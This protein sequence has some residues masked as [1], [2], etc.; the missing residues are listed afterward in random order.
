MGWVKSLSKRPSSADPSRNALVAQIEWTDV[1]KAAVAAKHFRYVSAGLD[2]KAKDRLTG[3][4]IGV[5][6]D[7]VAIVKHPFVQGMQP[8]SLSADSQTPTQEKRMKSVFKALGLKEDASEE[9]A[10]AALK[11]LTDKAAAKD[12]E[13]ATLKAQTSATDARIASLEAAAKAARTEK[14]TALL[15]DKIAKFAVDPSERAALLELATSSPETFEKLIGLRLPR[16]PSGPA[17]KVVKVP[18]DLLSRQKKAI[19]DYMAANAGVEEVD[20]VIACA[21]L[22]PDLFKE[23]A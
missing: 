3:K 20:A 8:L 9:D 13:I 10:A 4:E 12:A 11:A 1:G 2:M 19:S 22:H 5:M 16:D 23:V 15:D 6:L 21:S 14:L 17:L 7:H 18:S